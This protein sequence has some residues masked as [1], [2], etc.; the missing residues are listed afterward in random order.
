MQQV[1]EGENK[2]EAHLDDDVDSQDSNRE[3]H[4]QNEYPDEPDYGDEDSY[5]P[6]RED[7]DDNQMYGD[8]SDEHVD[9]IGHQP[10]QNRKQLK[11]SVIDK[12]FKRNKEWSYQNQMAQ[13]KDTGFLDDYE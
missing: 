1:Y 2:Q 6:Q 12:L 8:E 11:N 10:P 5:G 4:E 9:D 3:D 7:S 13:M